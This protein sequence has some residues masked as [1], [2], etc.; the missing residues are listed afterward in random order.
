MT[1]HVCRDEGAGPYKGTLRERG[2]AGKTYAEA[3]SS[4]GKR[5]VGPRRE[6]VLGDQPSED[7]WR[8]S[9]KSEGGAARGCGVRP[10]PS[11]RGYRFA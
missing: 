11:R 9:C 8:D 3:E 1:E 6:G 10:A 2:H 7:E 4:G 5:E